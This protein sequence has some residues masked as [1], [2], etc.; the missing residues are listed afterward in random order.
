MYG[1]ETKGLTAVVAL[2]A[3][4]LFL[5]ILCS[6]NIKEKNSETIF[7]GKVGGKIC[8]ELANICRQPADVKPQAQP[9][10]DHRKAVREMEG[11]WRGRV[12]FS[13]EEFQAY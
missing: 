9:P 8:A 6:D 4:M 5:K 13:V 3:R 1:G 2:H 11:S 10:A 7:K 12:T